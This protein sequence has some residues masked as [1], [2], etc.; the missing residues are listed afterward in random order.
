[1]GIKNRFCRANSPL[2]AL[3]QELQKRWTMH[4]DSLRGKK[5]RPDNYFAQYWAES[6]FLP[7]I[8]KKAS[9]DDTLN[10][11]KIADASS[12]SQFGT[13][14]RMSGEGSTMDFEAQKQ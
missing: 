7:T 12:G 10:L 6:G 3:E 11:S 5:P 4:P 8:V 2:E 1:L 9:N 14:G 13:G